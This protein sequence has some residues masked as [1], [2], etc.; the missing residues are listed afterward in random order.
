MGGHAPLSP[1]DLAE[2]LRQI[3]GRHIEPIL[4]PLDQVVPTF[5]GLGFS[6]SAATLMRE[7]FEGLSS[8][9]VGY[10]DPAA[11]HVRGTLTPVDVLGPTL[12]RA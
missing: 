11:P 7:M 8:G 3:L 2:S 12:A 9:R 10:Q 5:T 4:V 6:A 1:R